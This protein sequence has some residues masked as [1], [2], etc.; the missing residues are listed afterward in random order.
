MH[1]AGACACGLGDAI[2]GAAERGQRVDVVGL[3]LTRAMPRS[4]TSAVAAIPTHPRYHTADDKVDATSK[5]SA[6]FFGHPVARE[7]RGA[8]AAQPVMSTRRQPRSSVNEWWPRN[9]GPSGMNA[10]AFDR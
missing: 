2:E 8:I 3:R 6:A 7:E 1:P 10:K 9:R 5:N 4:D